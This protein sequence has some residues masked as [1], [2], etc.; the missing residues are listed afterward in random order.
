VEHVVFLDLDGTII[1]SSMGIVAGLREAF[2]AAGTAAPDEE[3]LRSWI[4]PPVRTTLERE[5][6]AHGEAAVS[7]ANQAFRAYFDEIG[8]HESV[9]FPGMRDAM[10]RMADQST[11]VVVTHKPKPLAEL[12]LSQHGLDDGVAA[13][14]APPRPSVFVAKED[15]FALAIAATR[16]RTAISVGDR[17]GDV[18]AAASHGIATVGVTWGFGSADEL[19]GAGAVA[20]ATAPVELPALVAPAGATP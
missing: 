1:D 12:A 11:I 4:G 18:E 8:A 14:H 9:P 7:A 16:P 19:Q 2:S 10:E 5:L 20:L 3:V 6:S 15:L 17:A 13:V